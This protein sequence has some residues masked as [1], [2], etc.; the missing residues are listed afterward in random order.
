MFKSFVCVNYIVK[1]IEY[2]DVVL[3]DIYVNGIFVE[4][5]VLLI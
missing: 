5:E 1:Y 4:M 3:E 2:L